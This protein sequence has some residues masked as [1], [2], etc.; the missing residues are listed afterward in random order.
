MTNT[1][2][3]EIKYIANRLVELTR[4]KLFLEAQSE[5]FSENALSI[6]PENSG[7]LSMVGLKAMQTKEKAF[8]EAILEWHRIEVSAPVISTN[9]FSVKML[10]EVTLKTGQS[11]TVDEIIVY[12]V[13]E[14][15]IVKEQFFY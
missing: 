11:I 14:G 4:Q 12:E 1:S 3:S 7:R 2:K 8:L 6:E 5:L 13:R 9:Y 15:K 10:V